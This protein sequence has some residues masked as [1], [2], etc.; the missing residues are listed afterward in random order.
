MT[1][2]ASASAAP[3]PEG[4][5]CLILDVYMDGMT[6]LELHERLAAADDPPPVIYITAHDDTATRDRVDRSG[7]LAYFRKPF[8][9]GALIAAIGRA[10]GCDLEP[11]AS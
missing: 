3:H 8:E 7:A 2:G 4:V 5:G 9:S 6:G 10:V 1:T 11:S